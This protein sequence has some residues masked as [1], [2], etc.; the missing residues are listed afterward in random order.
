M[1]WTLLTALILIT[2]VVVVVSMFRSGNAE[3]QA[4]VGVNTGSM[5]VERALYPGGNY[6]LSALIVVNTGQIAAD[7]SLRVVHRAEQE[8]LRSP[9]EWFT[10]HP[11]RFSLEPKLKQSVEVEVRL[12]VD[13]RPGEYFALIEAYPVAP[14]GRGATIQIGAA[15]KLYFRVVSQGCDPALTISSLGNWPASSRDAAT[16]SAF[17]SKG[18]VLVGELSLMSVDE[19]GK[20]PTVAGPPL[21]QR[22]SCGATHPQWNF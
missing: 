22:D 17:L 21:A 18:K 4:G 12:P 5:R 14:K 10:F 13:A 11:L 16:G 6:Q 20:L 1:R 9:K 7:Y 19:N 8:E 15:T 2:V 3:G